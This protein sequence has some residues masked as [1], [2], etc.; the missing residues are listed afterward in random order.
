[1]KE[2]RSPSPLID[3]RRP[4][5]GAEADCNPPGFVWRPVEG[6]QSYELEVGPEADFA[7]ASRFTVQGRCLWIYPQPLGRGTY[8][9]RWRALGCGQDQVW[10][11]VFQFSVTERTADLAIPSGAEVV[12]RI[13]AM[14]PRHLLPQGRLAAFRRDCATGER[15]G[16]WQALMQEGRTRLEANF[17]MTEPPFLPERSRDHEAWG[18]I[19]KDAMDHSRQMGQEAQL[20]ALI[21]L[22]EQDPE[23]G[24]AAIER[25][26]EF[27]CWD[28]E[29][30]TSTWHNNEPHM[31][32]INLAPRAYDWV[33]RL[34]EE[35]ERAQVREALRR[36][37]NQTLER[38]RRFNYGV[39]G[40]DNHSG[41]LLGF[42]GECGIVLAGECDEVEE[43]FDFILPTTVAMY[44]WWGGRQGG[45]AQGVS[46]SSA[47]CY[48]FY[49]FIYSLQQVAQIDFYRK[50]FFYGHG[51]WRLLCVPP[52][53]YMVPFGDGRTNGRGAVISSWGMQRHL[54]RMYGDQRFLQHAEQ[55]LESAGG[56]IV[57]SRGLFAPLSFLTEASPVQ[58]QALPA[59]EAKLFEDIGWLASRAD[60]LHPE[61]DVRFMMRASAYGS[62]SHSHADQNSYVLEAYGEPLAVPSGLYNLYGS[63]HHHGWT[64]QTRAHNGVTFD[65]AGQIVRVPEAVG[66]FK[67]YYS[68]QRLMYA[69]GDA[70]PAYDSRVRRSRRTV[71]GLDYRLFVLID[72]MVPR[73]EAMWTWHLHAIKPMRVAAQE[74]R[75]E[76]GYDKAG[77][78]VVVCHEEELLW[79]PHEGWDYVPFGYARQEDIP[80][81]AARYH[82]DI[83]SAMPK[84]CDVL[85]TVLCPWRQGQERAVVVPVWEEGV[86]GARIDWMGNSY[87]VRVEVGL[88]QPEPVRQI[89]LELAGQGGSA[90]YQIGGPPVAQGAGVVGVGMETIDG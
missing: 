19:W 70:S 34:M 56:S 59:A 66:R 32:V 49:H 80:V 14:R 35:G 74:R 52:N 58:E 69:L 13:G 77:L 51:E 15:R 83:G 85:V 46:Y 87:G 3:T 55:I 38:F 64:R 61:N 2:H 75:V 8:Y 73:T 27:A 11:Q 23:F 42:L 54:G 33:Y 88:E 79:R 5:D 20:F 24:R 81:E 65:G 4:F 18:R 22:I 40:T 21:Y 60:L 7:G 43:W 16:E 71:I 41:R 82:L 78:D 62:E 37:G 6:A 10:S 50:G 57:E 45:W 12:E 84:S 30:A 63:A 26:L 29:G 36:R 48:L 1:M 72:E 47:Y 17:M 68:D 9:W 44:P 90:Q 53:A 89:D 31:S 86:R 67:G 76:I 28:V 39:T 25:L